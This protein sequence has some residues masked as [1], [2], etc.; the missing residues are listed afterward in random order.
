MQPAHKKFQRGH[1]AAFMTNHLL[2]G[3]C[4]H[5][6]ILS[7]WSWSVWHKKMSVS[8]PFYL[9]YPVS[10]TKDKEVKFHGKTK[11][12]DK[13]QPRRP[14]LAVAEVFPAIIVLCNSS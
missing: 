4:F 1:G 10:K 14:K 13:C 9:W 5:S 3:K 12:D 8:H 11:N 2:I 7:H 6:Y